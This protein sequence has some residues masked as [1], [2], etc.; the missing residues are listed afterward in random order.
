MTLKYRHE[1]VIQEVKTFIDSSPL[2]RTSINKLIEKTGLSED[3][4]TKG[5][6]EL[7]GE[8]LYNYQL[9]LC[10]FAAGELLQSGLLVKS[11]A[12]AAGYKSQGSFTK[13]FFK[14]MGVTPSQ[15]QS[16]KLQH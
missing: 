5:F 8:T 14:V 13:A 10:M 2:E 3:K 7:W 1:L 11:V 9:R 12:F 16:E 6:K 4:L 15:Y